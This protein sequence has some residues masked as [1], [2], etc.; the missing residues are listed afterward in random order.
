MSLDK[1]KKLMLSFKNNLFDNLLLSLGL[2][3]YFASY[4]N[5][6]I[7]ASLFIRISGVLGIQMFFYSKIV[8]KFMNSNT[9]GELI[10]NYLGFMIIFAFIYSLVY[11]YIFLGGFGYMRFG[12]CDSS[13]VLGNMSTIKLDEQSSNYVY[14]SFSNILL[15]P[16]GDIC[17]MGVG[18]RI[19]SILQMAFS[20]IISLFFI[21]VLI[22][23]ILQDRYDKLYKSEIH[24][25][26]SNVYGK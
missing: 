19:A 16:Y 3:L 15:S 20:I 25:L 23:K 1:L 17:P 2:I 6:S 8:K 4:I 5:F 24:H 14:F 9:V 10:L 11:F 7:W 22:A 12:N 26:A 13:F 18:M 21:P